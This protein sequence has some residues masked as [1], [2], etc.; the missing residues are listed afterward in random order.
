MIKQ[1]LGLVI[2][3]LS[4][5]CKVNL[6]YSDEICDNIQQ[7]EEEQIKVQQYVSEL[8]SYNSIIQVRPK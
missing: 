1:I 7:H 8:Q 5:V 2:S 6:N 4:K 3:K